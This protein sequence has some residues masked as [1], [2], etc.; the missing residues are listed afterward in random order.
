MIAGWSNAWRI[1]WL[2]PSVFRGSRENLSIR[3]SI[4]FGEIFASI[5]IKFINNMEN[6]GV[7][8]R[9]MEKS[10]GKYSFSELCGKYEL[11]ELIFNRV[12]E[13]GAP[14]PKLKI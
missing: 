7:T 8:L 11:L 9:K 13:G 3:L 6:I 12:I 10:S 4:E 2:R 1:F 14:N 5:C